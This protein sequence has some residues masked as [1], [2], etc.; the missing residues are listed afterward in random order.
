MKAIYYRQ[1]DDLINLKSNLVTCLQIE[2]HIEPI[3]MQLYKIFTNSISSFSQPQTSA[4]ATAAANNS[5]TQASSSSSW[6]LNN[7]F[8]QNLKEGKIITGQKRNN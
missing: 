5:G 7:Q 8:R 3:R 2:P 4:N 1:S 6:Q